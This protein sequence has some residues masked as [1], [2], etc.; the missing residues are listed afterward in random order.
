[1]S[2]SRITAERSNLERKPIISIQNLIKIYKRGEIE[3]SAL[4]S[5]TVDFF[6]GEISVI[7]GPSGCGKTTLLNI[8]G[9]IITFDAGKVIV[10]GLDIAKLTEEELDE[11]RLNKV[12]YVFQFFNLIPELTAGDNIALQMELK[13]LEKIHISEEVIRVLELVDLL[14]KK[15][16]YPNELSGGEQQRIAIASG[17]AGNQKILLCD[18]PTGELDSKSKRQVMKLVKNIMNQFPEKSILIVTHDQEIK[19]IADRL[20]QIKDGQI[21]FVSEIDKDEEKHKYE[22]LLENDYYDNVT[23]EKA[24][25]LQE[26]IYF[27]QQRLKKLKK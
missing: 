24:V 21:A 7:M 10:D 26:T 15:D 14:D 18:E 16:N 13:N 11:Y 19:N 17:I 22:K 8:L 3:T 20:Y 27:L 6:P 2:E 23:A 25:Q 1:M 12:G 5:L 4:R 9:G